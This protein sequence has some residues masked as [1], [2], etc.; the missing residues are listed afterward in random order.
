LIFEE[1]EK[2]ISN[3]ATESKL[4]FTDVTQFIAEGEDETLDK[5]IKALE[6]LIPPEPPP[7]QSQPA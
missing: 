4:G 3:M 2:S 1:L 5:I 6:K 7:S